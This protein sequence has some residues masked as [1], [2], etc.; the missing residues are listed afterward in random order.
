MTEVE[1]ILK[2]FAHSAKVTTLVFDSSFTKDER[3]F[4]H[5]LAMKFNLK[6]KS[7][8]KDENRRI[9]IS[10][11]MEKWDLVKTLLREEG[12]ETDAYKLLIPD[13]FKHLWED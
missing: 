4:I 7:I 13:D 6:S 3:A 8:G 2:D 9:T 11:K 5:K 10:K 12:L 1:N